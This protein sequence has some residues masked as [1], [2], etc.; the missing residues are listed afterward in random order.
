MHG[1]PTYLS[2]IA[3]DL[4]RLAG[5]LLI[6]FALTHLHTTP[7][8]SQEATTT[9]SP[10]SADSATAT[11]AADET[12]V[13]APLSSPEAQD[14]IAIEGPDWEPAGYVGEDKLRWSGSIMFPLSDLHSLNI[15]LDAFRQGLD[16]G[17]E[18]PN[19]EK[20][21]DSNEET[22]D[23][24]LEELAGSEDDMPEEEK[25]EIPSFYLSSV[26]YMAPD[27]WIFWLNGKRISGEM[28]NLPEGLKV[29]D[30]GRN[31]VTFNWSPQFAS[32]AENRW[33]ERKAMLE[34]ND[35]P[36][37]GIA[38]ISFSRDKT[39]TFTLHPNQIFYTKEMA[40]VEGRRL[41]AASASP[42]RTA[43]T[44]TPSEA[45]AGAPSNGKNGRPAAGKP[46]AASLGG[47]SAEKR[48]RGNAD[49]LINQYIGVGESLG[50]VPSG[51]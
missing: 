49:Q 42:S 50:L 43:E 46:S 40:I 20:K 31:F 11:D 51:Q 22:L 23:K 8:A 19:A 2:R 32:E 17:I 3:G 12:A 36:L 25:K 21:K 6:A 47:T 37:A 34:A 7:A 4:S 35:L 16:A 24:I 26:L 13:A 14:D 41:R 15:V 10:L 33:N 44:A 27:N 28:A 18:D 39:V 48:D 9:P 45:V 30:L 38:G 1:Q 5:S 29:V